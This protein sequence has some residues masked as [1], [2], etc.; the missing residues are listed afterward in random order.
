MFNNLIKTIERTISFNL[1][2]ADAGD[3]ECS[4]Y[5]AGMLRAYL[6]VI[7]EFGHDVVSGTWDDKGCNRIGYV[8]ID[9]IVLVKKSRLDYKAYAKLMKE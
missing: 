2:R 1:D 8:E 3:I 6:D 4:N 5:T 9:G 7:M